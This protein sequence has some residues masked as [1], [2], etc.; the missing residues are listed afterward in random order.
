MKK[1]I[2]LTLFLT[3]CASKNEQYGDLL[4]TPK[5]GSGIELSALKPGQGVLIGTIEVN[6][7]PCV[8]YTFETMRQVTDK[9]INGKL[10]LESL[11]LMTFTQGSANVTRAG[12]YGIREFKCSG[13]GH[14]YSLTNYNKGSLLNIATRSYGTVEVIDGQVTNFGKISIN[15]MSL[16]LDEKKPF[17][18][19]S[20]IIAS[21]DRTAIEKLALQNPSL[22]AKAMTRVA[23]IIK[24]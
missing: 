1:V 12:L 18:F 8:N 19:A 5:S 2:I 4:S 16:P 15:V 10:K 6:G 3:A 20:S 7:L 9:P 21:D 17:I 23:N 13:S 14:H 24:R 22:S 11:S